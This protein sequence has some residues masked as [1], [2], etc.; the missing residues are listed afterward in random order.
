MGAT[1]EATPKKGTKRIWQAVDIDEARTLPAYGFRIGS[2][3]VCVVAAL[4]IL[5][6]I[7][8]IYILSDDFYGSAGNQP[9]GSERATASWVSL[10]LGLIDRFPPAFI[11]E[12]LII[13][14]IVICLALLASAFQFNPGLYKKLWLILWVTPLFRI[15]FL[16]A[17]ALSSFPYFWNKH[18]LGSQL[19]APDVLPFLLSYNTKKLVV[20]A[21]EFLFIFAFVR[22]MLLAK[23][24]NL[25]YLLRRRVRN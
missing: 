4:E 3:C 22:L 20:V 18:L 17:E 15:S 7:G 16:V 25:T 8:Y 5:I 6:D 12:A 14:H 19:P 11:A 21:I 23:S 13:I 10:F 9:F 2:F 24:P 1:D